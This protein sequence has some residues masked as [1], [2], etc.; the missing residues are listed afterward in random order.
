MSYPEKQIHTNSDS[1]V[2]QFRNGFDC[3]GNKINSREYITQIRKNDAFSHNE[4][5]ISKIIVE[6]EYFADYFAPVLDNCHLTLANIN[7][8]EINKCDFIDS[9]DTHKKYKSNRM[10]Y[11]GHDNIADTILKTFITSPYRVISTIMNSFLYLSHSL[12]VLNDHRI[13]HCDI[14]ENSVLC[15]SNGT[16]IICNFQKSIL[17]T[18]STKDVLSYRELFI[19]NPKKENACIEYQVLC[20]LFSKTESKWDKTIITQEHVST[21]LSDYYSKSKSIHKHI[22]KAEEKYRTYLNGFVGKEIRFLV[23]E[24]MHNVTHW[25]NFS[26]AV[27]YLHVLD[28]I[29]IEMFY[30]DYPFLKTFFDH[31]ITIVTSLPDKVRP[32]IKTTYDEIHD[33]FSV[34][35]ERTSTR[36]VEKIIDTIVENGELKNRVINNFKKTKLFLLENNT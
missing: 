12:N 7:D 20:F 2:C 30:K 35:V 32:T 24:F 28:D 21:V 10:A 8:N 17:V 11:I 4:S 33:L 6:L 29:K 3:N 18:T 14:K 5:Q 31:L 22:H 1:S 19:Y 23:K 27:I 15:N 13:I 26:L 36:N 25:D 9:R 16:P 34:E